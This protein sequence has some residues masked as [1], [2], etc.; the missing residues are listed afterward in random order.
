M[1]VVEAITGKRPRKV[2]QLTVSDQGA[3]EL[4]PLLR[5]LQRMGSQGSSRSIKIE[6]WDGNS[7]F[8][9]DGDGNAK[10]DEILVD[11][12]PYEGSE[13]EPKEE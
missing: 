12:D 7:N 9:F 6:D 2:I 1:N 10:I 13:D 8:G 4:L 5:E 11:G 3:E